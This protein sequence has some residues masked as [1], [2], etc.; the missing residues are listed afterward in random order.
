MI[1]IKIRQIYFK[2]FY[3]YLESESNIYTFD[4]IDDFKKLENKN[5]FIY[6]ETKI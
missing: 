1:L 2:K 5:K 4:N 3:E 6:N